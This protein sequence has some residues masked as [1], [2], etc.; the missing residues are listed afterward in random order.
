MRITARNSMCHIVN[1]GRF[2][3]KGQAMIEI[4]AS[5]LMFVLMICLMLSV[6]LFLYV[7]HAAVTAVREGTRFAALNQ[8]IGQAST[9][10]AGVDEVKAYLINATEQ[11]SGVTIGLDDIDVTPPD[12][13]APQG[14]RTVRIDAHFMMNNPV[15][16][17]SLLQG[18]GAEGDSLNSFPIYATATMRYEE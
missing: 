3:S 6:S 18:L 1:T 10:I 12:P 5:L 2:K 8:D 13:G 11:L 9:Q 14:T 7:Q 4:I 17:G 15:P 16:V